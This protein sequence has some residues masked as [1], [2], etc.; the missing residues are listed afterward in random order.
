MSAKSTNQTASDLRVK[1]LLRHQGSEE[2]FKEG[3]WTNNPEEAK[4][5]SDVV[6][7]AETCARYGLNNVE[8]ALRVDS[9][10]GDVF[11]TPIR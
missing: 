9:A 7:V 5:F 8:L 10:A 2:Y 11:C 6:E 4:C 1:R 3:G